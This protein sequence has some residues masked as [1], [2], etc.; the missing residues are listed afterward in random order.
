MFAMKTEKAFY[1]QAGAE[2]DALTSAGI[3]GYFIQRR[4]QILKSLSNGSDTVVLDLGCGTG[5]YKDA[6]LENQTVIG[7]DYSFSALKDY[8]K[9]HAQSILVNA[10]ACLIPLLKESVD[11]VIMFGL[12]HHLYTRIDDLL[13]EIRRVLKKDGRIIID[14]PNG[15]NL[16]WH[17]FLRSEKGLRI[18]GGFTKPL[19]PFFLKK[20]L[21]RCGFEIELEKNWGFFLP[22][23]LK[24]RLFSF[25]DLYFEKLP[26]KVFSIRFTIAGRKK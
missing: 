6:F 23:F 8:R 14:E 1:E 4:K 13:Q 20:K 16:L 9:K 3:F 12:A 11:L 21:K 19:M 24:M 25:L 22:W 7:Q 5:I 18:D 10:D 15:Y 17:I 26:L 2:Y